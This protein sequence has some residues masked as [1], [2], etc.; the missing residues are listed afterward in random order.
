MVLL[1]RFFLYQIP[2]HHRGAHATENG[3]HIRYRSNGGAFVGGR[4]FD[5]GV[6]GHPFGR[7]HHFE[8]R[9]HAQITQ[10]LAHHVCQRAGV[11]L[12]HVGHLHQR[13]VEFAG[14]AH[15]AYKRITRLKGVID[16]EHLG[17]EGVDGVHNVVEMRLLQYLYHTLVAK[18]LVDDMQ[19]AVGVYVVQT[20]P[21]TSA[22]G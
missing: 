1:C 21:Q 9:F 15:G 5:A 22:L 18:K 16:K 3:G 20:L 13:G 12:R 19:L 6:L 8:S 10:P 11:R 7:K 2:Y 4:V 14:A 17:R